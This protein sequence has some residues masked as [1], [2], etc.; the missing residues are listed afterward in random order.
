MGPHNQEGRTWLRNKMSKS[1]QASFS[2]VSLLLAVS[3]ICA[4]TCLSWP[5]AAPGL[6]SEGKG[7]FSAPAEN[8]WEGPG[9]VRA[10]SQASHYRVQEAW[11]RP[12]VPAS[13]PASPP[14]PRHLYPPISALSLGHRLEGGFLLL[15]WIKKKYPGLPQSPTNTLFFKRILLTNSVPYHC[16]YRLSMCMCVCM[17]VRAYKCPVNRNRLRAAFSKSGLRG[18]AGAFR[19]GVSA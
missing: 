11:E 10:P 15:L 14:A 4:R 8:P 12:P 3:S 5:P 7:L 1:R 2:V 19:R 17:H 13:L 9:W 18:L 6:G 16:S